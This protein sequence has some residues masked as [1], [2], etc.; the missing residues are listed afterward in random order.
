MSLA[1][2]IPFLAI[3]LI[4]S[5]TGMVHGAGWNDPEFTRIAAVAFVVMIVVTAVYFNI[6]SWIADRTA[7]ETASTVRRNAR[8]AAL[9]YIWGAAAMFAVYSLSDLSWRHAWQYG[10]G[11]LVIGAGITLYV[12]R[13]GGI[14]VPPLSL[15]VLH[16]LAAGGGLAFLIGS[17][18]LQTVKS[19]WVANEVF[20]FGGIGIMALCVLT[21]ATQLIYNRLLKS[22]EPAG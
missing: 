6:K 3:G 18:K 22:S 11:M 4:I 12:Y 14:R 1:P 10:L 7:S 2:L 19:D 13:L 5:V 21:L 15:T 20:L 8:L 9:I 17:G 16:G